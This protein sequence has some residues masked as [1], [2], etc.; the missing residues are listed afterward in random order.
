MRHCSKRI[1]CSR[2]RKK[3]NGFLA[4][5]PKERAAQTQR[6]IPQKGSL[7]RRP[8]RDLPAHQGDEMAGRLPDSDNEGG[9]QIN[10]RKLEFKR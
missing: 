1:H 5:E 9:M 4:A 6:E 8:C 7:A 10:R 2:T 3:F